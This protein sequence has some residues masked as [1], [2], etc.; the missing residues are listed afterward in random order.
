M[1]RGSVHG[2]DGDAAVGAPL[3]GDLYDPARLRAGASDR[4]RDPFVARVV[5]AMEL[6]VDDDAVGAR[7]RVRARGLEVVRPEVVDAALEAPPPRRAAPSR[8]VWAYEG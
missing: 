4:G 6:V 2:A 1:A 5:E 7:R 3:S 8:C